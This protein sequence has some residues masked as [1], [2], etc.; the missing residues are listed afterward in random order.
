[1]QVAFVTTTSETFPV[2]KRWVQYHKVLGVSTFYLFVDG[3]ASQQSV[4]PCSLL[5]S[6]MF[7]LK[8]AKAC[9]SARP[10][11][12]PLLT[13]KYLRTGLTCMS[14]ARLHCEQRLCLSD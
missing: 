6:V 8:D 14:S 2:I 1:M 3:Q 12:L 7:C 10:S 5:G 9:M 13:S 4:R 11:M